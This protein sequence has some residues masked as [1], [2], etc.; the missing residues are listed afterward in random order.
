MCDQ[1]KDREYTYESQMKEVKECITT[2]NNIAREFRELLVKSEKMG[3]DKT[4]VGY[5]ASKLCGTGFKKIATPLGTFLREI[6]QSFEPC[7][8]LPPESIT[9]TMSQ[10][11]DF[12]FDRAVQD[13]KRIMEAKGVV[14]VI[15]VP[16]RFTRPTKKRKI[17][18]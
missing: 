13:T 5:A 8:A 16:T 17:R 15:P 4:H 1:K 12:F 2:A 18:E 3:K 11:G 9:W 6:I 10:K 14:K 7:T